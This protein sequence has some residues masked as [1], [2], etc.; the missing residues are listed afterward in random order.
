[1]VPIEKFFQ[2]LRD[3]FQPDAGVSSSLEAD[4]G[5][6]EMHVGWLE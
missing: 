2:L 4:Q 1:M 6:Y 3:L 5:F